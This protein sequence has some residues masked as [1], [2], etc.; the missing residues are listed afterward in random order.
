MATNISGHCEHL[1]VGGNQGIFL[2]PNPLTPPPA[3]TQIS[4]ISIDN[5]WTTSVIISLHI[6]ITLGVLPPHGLLIHSEY[7]LVSMANSGTTTVR[8]N[9]SQCFHYS[10][11]AVTNSN[12]L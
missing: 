7:V 1:D 4:E 2:Y 6:Y 3:H 12:P 5:W 10:N 11:R 8:P 9:R